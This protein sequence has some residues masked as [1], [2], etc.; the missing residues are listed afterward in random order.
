MFCEV[1]GVELPDDSLFC[2]KCGIPLGP[3]NHS[4]N[5]QASRTFSNIGT[6]VFGSFALLSLVVSLAKGIVPIYLFEALL[7]GAI[8]WIWHRKKP[9]NRVLNLAAL[10]VGIAVV[11]GEGY[12]AGRR[13]GVPG[14]TPQRSSG[15]LFDQLRAAQPGDVFDRISQTQPAVSSP[16]PIDEALSRAPTKETAQ[17]QAA[18]RKKPKR[19]LPK[20]HITCS[21]EILY[22]RPEFSGDRLAVGTLEDRS[23]VSIEGEDSLHS[24][25]LVRSATGVRGYVHQGCV[26]IEHTEEREGSMVGFGR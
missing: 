2:R 8:A 26:T 21:D 3:A 7:W 18:E 19:I 16:N 22:D 20:G 10:V 6:V 5:P 11:A 15:D 17:P 23:I 25:Y 9:A 4:R 14:A 12:M 24:D 13:P 1:C